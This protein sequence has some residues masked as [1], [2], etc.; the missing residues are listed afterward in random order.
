MRR[1]QSPGGYGLRG[2]LDQLCDLHRLGNRLRDDRFCGR[3]RG[4]FRGDGFRCHCHGRRE[5]FRCVRRPRAAGL[6]RDL[7]ELRARQVEVLGTGGGRSRVPCGH[8]GLRRL[9]GSAVGERTDHTAGRRPA[10]RRGRLARGR[11]TV[12]RPAHGG[13]RDR[14]GNGG[15]CR[16]AYAIEIDGT[17]ITAAR[18]VRALPGLGHHPGHGLL[19]GVHGRVRCLLDLHGSLGLHGLRTTDVALRLCLVRG[20]SLQWRRCLYGAAAHRLSGDR[21]DLRFAPG[22]LRARHQ[23]KIVVLGRMLGGSEEGV[24]TR[25]GVARLLHH[26]CVLR[27]SL[28]RDL[29]GVTHAYPSPIVSAPSALRPGRPNTARR[30]SS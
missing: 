30:R 19:H 26:A 11:A 10:V 5:L 25:G 16:H 21:C 4:R 9:G 27:Q 15:R 8:R 13:G 12:Q 22:A 2:G 29:A 3:F 7:A 18:L 24:R 6:R 20:L 14:C 28:A 1:S 17:R 23:Q